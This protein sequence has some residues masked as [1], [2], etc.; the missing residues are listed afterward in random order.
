MIILKII[1]LLIIV[2]DPLY[3][4]IQTQLYAQSNAE[5]SLL[6]EMLGNDLYG[7]C[8]QAYLEG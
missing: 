1:C 2:Y 7:S 3:V 4:S 6:Q 8:N 5:K